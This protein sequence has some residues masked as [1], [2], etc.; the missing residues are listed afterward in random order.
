MG[1]Y[2]LI[3]IGSLCPGNFL[4]FCQCRLPLHRCEGHQSRKH[5]EWNCVVSRK[6]VWSERRCLPEG[7]CT[8][9][10]DKDLGFCLSFRCLLILLVD[11]IWGYKLPVVRALCRNVAETHEECPWNFSLH[12]LP[13]CGEL[14]ACRLLC[15]FGLSWHMQATLFQDSQIG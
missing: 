14:M 9:W 4:P 11:L 7:M 6:V 1:F 15:V 8:K 2:P 13:Q 5:W 3:L 12:L 10:Q